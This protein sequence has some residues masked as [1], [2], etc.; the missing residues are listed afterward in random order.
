M[1]E[2]CVTKAQTYSDSGG[3]RVRRLLL[4]RITAHSSEG[5]IYCNK[6]TY[7]ME[8]LQRGEISGITVSNKPSVR[9]A[10]EMANLFHPKFHPTD[11]HH[12][13]SPAAVWIERCLRYRCNVV[14][15]NPFV[16]LTDYDQ[17]PF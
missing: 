11:R 3:D 15:F 14:F 1:E 17:T 13:P 12:E 8:K 2:L 5:E 9:T 16:L 7:N 10:S 4:C 6:R